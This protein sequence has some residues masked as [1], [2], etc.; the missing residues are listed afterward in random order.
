MSQSVQEWERA[1]FDQGMSPSFHQRQCGRGLFGQEPFVSQA[2]EPVG[3]VIGDEDEPGQAGQPRLAS[4]LGWRWR[5]HLAAAA[6]RP[7][8]RF[9]ASNWS[10]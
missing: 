8:K 10:A 1:G 9:G 5:P 6:I 4:S 7:G 2:D 3:D